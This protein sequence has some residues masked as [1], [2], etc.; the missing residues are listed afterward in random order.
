MTIEVLQEVTEWQ[1]DVAVANGIYHVNS[2]GH[3]VGYE[4][5]GGEFKQFKNPLKRFSKARRRFRKLRVYDSSEPE[6]ARVKFV[7]GSKGTVYRVDLDE[8]T[9]SCPGFTYRGSCKHVNQA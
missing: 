1:G 3:L 5:P 6:S 7:T 8:G 2:Q 4:P 9:C